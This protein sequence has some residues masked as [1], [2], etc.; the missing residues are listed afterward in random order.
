M[1]KRKPSIRYETVGSAPLSRNTTSRFPLLIILPSVGHA[2]AVNV[3][4]AG[5]NDMESTPAAL[6]TVS[7]AEAGRLSIFTMSMERT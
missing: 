7:K 1:R 5:E 3:E 6:K 2:D 4:V